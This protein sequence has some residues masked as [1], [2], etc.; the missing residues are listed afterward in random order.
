MSFPMRTFEEKKSKYHCNARTSKNLFQGSAEKHPQEE[1][2]RIPKI[3]REE[4]KER[5]S[6]E[7]ARADLSTHKGPRFCVF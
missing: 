5:G 4:K 1:L 2:K 7:I 3:P 6:C